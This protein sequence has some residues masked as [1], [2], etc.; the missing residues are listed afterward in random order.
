MGIEVNKIV[1]LVLFNEAN[2]EDRLIMPSMKE[3]VQQ[4]RSGK[5]NLPA[6]RTLRGLLLYAILEF[7]YNPLQCDL[8]KDF[9]TEQTRQE[10]EAEAEQK[11]IAQERATRIDQEV[12]RLVDL[13]C[14][15]WE[16]ERRQDKK[17]FSLKVT[18]M[19]WPL[20]PAT[21]C[22]RA[23][24]TVKFEPLLKQTLRELA[25]KTV[26]EHGK[27]LGLVDVALFLA[28]FTRPN[29]NWTVFCGQGCSGIGA[30]CNE[31]LLQLARKN[32]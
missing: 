29:E 3:V 5:L 9:D 19:D 12:K 8:T 26:S 6:D 23:G 2:D 22:P 28:Q 25:E 21:G 31:V 17:R 27:R 24:K 10:K 13:A 32:Q 30:R 1:V 11:K 20:S 15:E 4:V 18:E 14:E 7:G 16:F